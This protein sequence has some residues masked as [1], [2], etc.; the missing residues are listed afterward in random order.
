MAKFKPGDMVKYTGGEACKCEMC[1]KAEEDEYIGYIAFVRQDAFGIE[2]DIK[3]P[4]GAFVEWI[5]EEQLELFIVEFTMD[6]ITVSYEL[7]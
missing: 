1:K 5:T 3:F 2:Y 4:S 7:D 6:D